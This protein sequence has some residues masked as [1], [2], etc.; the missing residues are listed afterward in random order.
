MIKQVDLK[1]FKCFKLL[2][3]PARPLT[4]LSGVNAS[5]KSSVMHA[6]AI[7]H[8]TMR[9]HEWSSR[10][11]LNGS[12]VRLGTVTDVLD[13]VHGRKGCDITIVGS[14]E[15]QYSWRFEGGRAEMSMAVRNVQGR[16]EDGR[17]LDFDATK[18][19]RYL[20]PEAAGE[21]TL[22]NCL[23][24]MTYLTAER[25]GPRDFYSHD[26]PQLTPVVGPKGEYAVS[27]LHSNF[28]DPVLSGLADE[29]VANT[30]G[31]QVE[32]RMAQFFP[33]FVFQ[34]DHIPRA[35][36]LTLGIRISKDTGFLRPIHTGFGL[37]QVLPIVVAA[38]AARDGQ[39][40]LIENPEVH[41][42]PSGQ[43]AMGE[44]LAKIA[45]AGVQVMIETHSDH[46]LNGIRRAVK[47]GTLAG[48]DVAFH[49]FRPRRDADTDADTQVQSPE[50]D[51]SGN[52]DCW[53]V[54][55]FDQFDRDMNYFAGWG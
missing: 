16:T 25:V 13:Q 4:M 15:A 47:S 38:L 10:L 5:G 35:S 42:H 55:F 41:L 37:T 8:Q 28:E 19:L 6:L 30:L 23:R 43:A 45:S 27:I 44:F 52:L 51:D 39:L 50:L 20:L 11:M 32:N 53:P 3:L 2:R 1:H 17:T 34:I 33:G 22:T 36:S 24:G 14:N 7:L 49:F 9:E 46:V 29:G 21:D 40:L 12:A 54:G 26:D 18:P 48:R 31:R